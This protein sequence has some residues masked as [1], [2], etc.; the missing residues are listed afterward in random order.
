MP[1][2]GEIKRRKPREIWPDEARDFTPWLAQ[3]IAQLGEALGMD[4]ELTAKE[5]AVGGFCCDLLAK[6]LST[7]RIVVIEN[8]F[9]STDHDHLGKAL[10]YAAG[11]DARAIVWIAE[12][13]RDE[14]RQTLEWLNA[15]TDD[16]TEFYA[17]VVEVI[18]IDASRPAV[19]FNPVVFP[20]DWRK[21]TRQR[22]EVAPLTSRREA[23][24]AFF[25][26]L[27]DELREE[28]HFT[29]S[30]KA[31]PQNWQTFSI[32]YTGIVASASFAMGDRVRTEIYIDRGEL[33]ENKRIFSAL[34]VRRAE[35]DAAF[36]E[37]LSWERLDDK[38]ASRIALYRP[39]SIEAE[40]QQLEQIRQ[41]IV[42]S[43]LKLSRFFRRLFLKCL[44]NLNNEACELLFLML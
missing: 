41:W 18:Q 6:D 9:G 20:N 12:K 29:N 19:V 35:F 7:D 3:H 5:T 34:H 23:Y 26:Q 37:P 8:Q 44:V 39:G 25:Q 2:L 33:D 4:L 13:T 10:T 14:H 36:N 21:E 30:R 1:D 16:E 42:Q 22:T 27:I 43:L 24:R 17:V 31:Q 15:H 40:D 32:G 11:L 28:H 38:R